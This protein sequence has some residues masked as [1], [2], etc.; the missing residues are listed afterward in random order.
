MKLTKQQLFERVHKQ[1]LASMGTAVKEVYSEENV[2]RIG[3]NQKERCLKVSF[4]NGEWF[5]YYTDG[6]WG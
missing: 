3:W 5:H 2:K 1:H 4:N 6:T